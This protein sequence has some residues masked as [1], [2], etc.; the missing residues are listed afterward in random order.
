MLLAIGLLLCTELN[1][2]LANSKID[3]I[4]DNSITLSNS[5]TSYT[6]DH[7]GWFTASGTANYEYSFFQI[8]YPSG[9]T[10]RQFGGNV[11]Y[12]VVITVPVKKGQTITIQASEITNNKVYKFYY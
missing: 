7:N 3:F 5:I 6:P 11:G 2:N 10:F 4:G 8:G 1:S 9:L 12:G